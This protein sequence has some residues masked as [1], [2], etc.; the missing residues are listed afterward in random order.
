MLFYGRKMKLQY[1]FFCLSCIF[2]GEVV[3]VL[4][5]PADSEWVVRTIYSEGAKLKF[6]TK[7]D[8]TYSLPKDSQD[9]LKPLHIPLQGSSFC[10]LLTAGK[11]RLSP[12]GKIIFESLDV[13]CSLPGGSVKFMVQSSKSGRTAPPSATF[14]FDGGLLKAGLWAFLTGKT[15]SIVPQNRYDLLFRCVRKKQEIKDP[16]VANPKSIGMPGTDQLP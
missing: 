11:G 3:S 9:N 1:L 12:E 15:T 7:N 10:S 8:K 4:A 2:F 5:C 14:S 13:Y 6:E 16:V